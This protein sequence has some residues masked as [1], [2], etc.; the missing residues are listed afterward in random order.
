MAIQ[1]QYANHILDRSFAQSNARVM[2]QTVA[3]EQIALVLDGSKNAEAILPYALNYARENNAELI[4]I[5]V[6][7]TGMSSETEQHAARYLKTV[8]NKLQAQYGNVTA[9]LHQG[10]DKASALASV[11]N[12]DS[13]TCVLFADEKRNM[14]QRLLQANPANEL[15]HSH[16]DVIIQQ[17]TI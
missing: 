3:I 9:F 5:H 1:N 8:R 6:Y 17:V 2:T 7:Q 16:T 13:K 11:I 15:A 4:I 14:L 12:N 10:T